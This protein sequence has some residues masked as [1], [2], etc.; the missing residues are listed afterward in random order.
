PTR[1]GWRSWG[2][3]R[4]R[5]GAR[6]D[7]RESLTTETVK[8]TAGLDGTVE[9]TDWSHRGPPPAAAASAP[10]TT[11][12]REPGLRNPVH[13]V[14]SNTTVDVFAS[15]ALQ[16]TIGTTSFTAGVRNLFRLETAHPLQL[17]PVLRRSDVRLRRTLRLGSHCAEVLMGRGDGA[18]PDVRHERA[19][20][21]GAPRPPRREDPHR[22]HDRTHG[23]QCPQP[24]AVRKSGSTR[25]EGHRL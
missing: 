15:Y 12:T 9:S 1:F 10:T 8:L 5:Q 14:S 18:E 20:A 13:H 17:V 4:V 24:G 6:R 16:S 11:W 19:R 7:G 2:R 23:G 21:P 3:P 25:S 22:L